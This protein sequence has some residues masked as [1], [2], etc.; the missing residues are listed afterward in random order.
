[1]AEQVSSLLSR[2]K[3]VFQRDLLTVHLYEGLVVG[4][5][6]LA[7]ARGELR[8]FILGLGDAATEAA[9]LVYVENFNFTGRLVCLY[10]FNN[11]SRFYLVEDMLLQKGRPKQNARWDLVE[12]WRR[13]AKYSLAIFFFSRVL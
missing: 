13:L 10:F 7:L 3:V 9:L 12:V 8:D 5:F 6:T 2:V 4:E 1:M 11:N